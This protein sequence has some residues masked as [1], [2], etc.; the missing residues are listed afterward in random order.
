MKISKNKQFALVGTV[1][2]LCVVILISVLLTKVAPQQKITK[3]IELGNKYLTEMDYEQAIVAFEQV[4]EIDPM[5]ADAYIGLTDAYICLNEFDKAYKTAKQGYEK[6]GDERLNEKMQMI[7]SG[8]I[9]DFEG[10][11]HKMTCYG[12]DGSIESEYFYTYGHNEYG[13]ITHVKELFYEEGDIR[14]EYEETEFDENGIQI[15]VRYDQ[16]GNMTFKRTDDI[17]KS[18][19]NKIITSDYTYE[20]ETGEL[21][22]QRLVVWEYGQNN[23]EEKTTDYEVDIKTGEKL[24]K[25]IIFYEY[26]ENN[27]CI[28]VKSYDAD[29]NLD[30]RTESSY[31][32]EGKLTEYRV[33]F[34]TG[35]LFYKRV[36]IYD[37]SG[38]YIGY[39]DYDENGNIKETA[40]V[41]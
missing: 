9:V 26:D 21:I 16:N 17:R 15:S 37:D 2:L 28:V 3:Q 29:G 6:T 25:K 32:A 13:L 35:N 38:N 20:P 8:N 7:E 22:R 27:N 1:V 4:I 18:E 39:M 11:T 36:M 41:E 10:R 24:I 34:P 40:T 5:N 12:A 33:Y 30:G 23:K 19:E 14:E 31:D